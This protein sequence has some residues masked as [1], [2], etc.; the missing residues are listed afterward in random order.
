VRSGDHQATLDKA[1]SFNWEKN[2]GGAQESCLK[3]IRLLRNS[4]NNY[5]NKYW[6]YEK[7]WMKR[8]ES[9]KSSVEMVK[10]IKNIRGNIIQTFCN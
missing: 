1:Y 3:N 5:R 9:A 8:S 10:N 2:L 4:S 6:K 7:V